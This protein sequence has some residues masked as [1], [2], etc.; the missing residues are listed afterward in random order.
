[1]IYCIGMRW[2]NGLKVLARSWQGVL[3]ERPGSL[4]LQSP[5]KHFSPELLA[6]IFHCHPWSSSEYLQVKQFLTR[7]WKK[8][9]LKKLL[10]LSCFILSQKSTHLLYICIIKRDDQ[11]DSLKSQ[12]NLLPELLPLLRGYREPALNFKYAMYEV[13]HWVFTLS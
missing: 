7:T 10:P 9:M 2:E 6:H 8:I 12:E 3:I 13:P 4:E 11:G 1:M 5:G